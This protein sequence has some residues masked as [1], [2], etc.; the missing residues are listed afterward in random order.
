MQITRGSLKTREPCAVAK[1]RQTNV[2]SESNGSKAERLNG[3]VYHDI[4]IVKENND[5]K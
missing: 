5:D 3:R 4:A 2:S 1:A